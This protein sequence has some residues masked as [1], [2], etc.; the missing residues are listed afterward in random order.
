MAFISPKSL[1]FEA[2]LSQYQDNPRYELA[3][4]ELINM[5]PTGP[6]FTT[7]SATPSPPG[8]CPTVLN[9]HVRLQLIE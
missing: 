8:G 5:E 1:T 4:G 3:D 7:F 9:N 2:F 6:H